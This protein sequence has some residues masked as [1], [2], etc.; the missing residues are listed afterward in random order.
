MLRV[1]S[2]LVVAVLIVRAAERSLVRFQLSALSVRIMRPIDNLAS[3][4]S[5]VAKHPFVHPSGG[6]MSFVSRMH[7]NL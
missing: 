6:I 7:P 5:S 4:T 3:C 2:S 1:S